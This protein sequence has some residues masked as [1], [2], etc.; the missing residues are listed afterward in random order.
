[1]STVSTAMPQRSPARRPFLMLFAREKLLPEA[2]PFQDPIDEICEK[3]APRFLR[4]THYLVAAL[5]IALVTAAALTKVDVVVVA[6]GRIATATPPIVLQ[7]M[8]RAIIREMRVRPGDA[9]SAGQVLATLDPTF[10]AADADALEKQVRNLRG[11]VRRLEAES[12]GTRFDDPT[13]DDALQAT[14]YRQ[15]QAEYAARIHVFD[16]DI[17]RLRATL[18]TL[19]NDR[20]ALGRELDV[21]REVEK[22]R[23]ALLQMQSGS[24][25]NWLESESVRM[26]AERDQQDASDRLL[27]I[28]HAME[29]RQAERQA[30][31]DGW[32]RDLLD[33][34]VTARTELARA[35][36]ALAKATRLQDLVVVK[37]PEDGVVLDVAQRTAGSVLREAEPLLT[38]IPRDATLIAEVRIASGDVGDTIPGAAVQLKID[39]FPYQRH[40]LVPGRLLSV[41]E[42]SFSGGAAGGTAPGAAGG[43]V[44]P[45]RVELLSTALERVPPGARLFPGMTLTAEIKA[46]TRSVLSY[47]LSPLTR[48]FNESIREP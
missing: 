34:L 21:A 25:L 4:T 1:M 8:D 2:L 14:L 43:A 42:E 10:A 13:G 20:G 33:T 40:G 23:S 46:G 12:E 6:G 44:H 26:H 19:D 5:F 45:G 48:G 37:A 9:V 32:R 29:S 24:R 30:F 16:E 7:P 22:M 35:S 39:A 3:P 41:G 28:V 38:M 11:Q 27:E 17:A 18:R 47:F 15:R 36:A 31:V